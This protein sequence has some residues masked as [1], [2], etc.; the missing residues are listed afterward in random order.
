MKYQKKVKNM[1]IV[2]VG[3]IILII[4]KSKGYI[5]WGII[6][7]KKYIE[8]LEILFLKKWDCLRC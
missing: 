2:F 5:I 3:L 7:G 6:Q 1:N 8:S 4:K